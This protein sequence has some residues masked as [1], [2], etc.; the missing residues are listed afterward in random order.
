MK[1]SFSMYHHCLSDGDMGT[2]IIAICSLSGPQSTL[3]QQ[4]NNGIVKNVKQN[5]AS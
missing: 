4:C 2:Q 5:H 1:I 3:S